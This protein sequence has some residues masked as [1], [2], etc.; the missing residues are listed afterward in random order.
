MRASSLSN[1]RVIELVSRYFVPV[2]VSRDNYQLGTRPAAEWLELRRLDRDTKQRGLKGGTVCVYIM[3]PDGAVLATM[4]VHQA[5]DPKN[6][7]P[8]IEQV[9]EKQ[10]LTPRNPEAVQASAVPR[11]PVS[12]ETKGGVVLHVRTKNEGPRARYGVSEDWV[13][14]TPQEWKAFLPEKKAKAGDS[15]QVPDKVADKL[16][17]YFYPPGPNWKIKDSTVL[18]RSLTVTVVSATDKEVRVK[19]RGSATLSHPFGDQDTPGKV[20]AKVAGILRYDP[21]KKELTSFLIAS[22][23]AEFVWQ[24]RNRPQPEKMAIAVE[25]EPRPE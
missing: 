22:E 12:P 16:F 10:K 24:W 15:R 4:P 21:A 13:Q 17:Q 20:T 6:L 3:A 5:V 11:K 2:W 1:A 25:L 8:L 18:N 23:Q 9:I 7:V 19:L 14:L